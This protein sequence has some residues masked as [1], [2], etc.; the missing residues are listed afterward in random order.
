MFCLLGFQLKSVL[1]YIYICTDAI[2]K[3]ETL[4]NRLRPPYRALGRR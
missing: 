4:P 2:Q 3:Y 1:P